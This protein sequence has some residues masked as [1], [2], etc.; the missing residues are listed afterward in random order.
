VRLLPL[1]RQMGP[2]PQNRF[3]VPG[4]QKLQFIK[5]SITRKNI[6]AG[7]Y[8]YYDSKH[9]ESFEDQVLYHY[10]AI[11]DRLIIGKFCSI[12]PGT[13]FLM[14]GSNHRMD[15]STFP[16]HLFGNG[17]EQ[18][19]PSL[20]ALP[21]K[22]D[23]KVGNDVWIG[24]DAT[25]LPGVTIGDGAIIAARSV[26]TKDV[27]PYCVVGGNPAKLIKKRYPDEVIRDWLEIRWW[28][29]DVEEIHQNLEFII[30]GEIERLK[31]HRRS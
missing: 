29:W 30:N 28:D 1:H 21:L 22:G 5:P 3:P 23:T 4:N 7:E 17:W 19:V 6:I 20:E 25:I 2:D 18:H 24:R 26:V 14:N 15:G 16:F 27:S 31:R 13:T 8:S 11:G 12:G 9:G 10:E